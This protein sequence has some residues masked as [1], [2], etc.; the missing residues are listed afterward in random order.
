AELTAGAALDV[1]VGERDQVS[2]AQQEAAGVGGRKDSAAD[3]RDQRS[4]ARSL[5]RRGDGH[6]IGKSGDPGDRRSG[7]MERS[8]SRRERL[9]RR[10]A[11]RGNGGGWQ[12]GRA[13]WRDSRW[14]RRRRS[15]SRSSE[16][17]HTAR[18][19]RSSEREGRCRSLSR[20]PTRATHEQAGRS[21]RPLVPSGSAVVVEKVA[22]PRSAAAGGLS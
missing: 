9:D 19:R 3:P 2:R 13:E 16:R 4:M 10:S 14:L 6:S 18:R 8:G 15:E 12:R 11:S 17:N 22:P 7:S 20:T 1:P 5:G 21:R